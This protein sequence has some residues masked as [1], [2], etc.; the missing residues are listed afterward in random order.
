MTQ[1]EAR[2]FSQQISLEQFGYPVNVV[3][4]VLVWLLLRLLIRLLRV[5]GRS[6]QG[7]SL[8]VSAANADDVFDLDCVH[9]VFMC[10][11]LTLNGNL[12]VLVH[13]DHGVQ[14]VNF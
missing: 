2:A 5:I 13:F 12:N 14:Q 11:F 3:V 10:V 1:V 4:E 7:F 9:F 6:S 8:K